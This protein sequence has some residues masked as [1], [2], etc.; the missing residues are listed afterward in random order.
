M[1][2]LI[3]LLCVGLAWAS[4]LSEDLYARL[5]ISRE[6]T[7]REVRVAFKKKAL[8]HHPDKNP[9][10]D[11]AHARMI[12]L[13]QAL[14]I[15]TD[16]DQRAAYDHGGLKAAEAAS[17]SNQGTKY[18]PFSKF[19]DFDAYQ[20]FALYDEDVQV[21]VL[22]YMLWEASHYSTDAWFITFY[23]GEC[24]KCHEIAPE[25]RKVGSALHGPFHVAAVNCDS[26]F[27]VC[28]D[29]GVSALPTTLLFKRGTPRNQ[30]HPEVYDPTRPHTAEQ[31]L[32]F[33]HSH[34]PNIIQPLLPEHF[35][36]PS[37][38]P[39]NG[40]K[41]DLWVVGYC[42]DPLSCESLATQIKLIGM[43][44]GDFVPV[45]MANCEAFNQVC[46]QQRA[47][48]SAPDARAIIVSY[49]HDREIPSPADRDIRDIAYE[50]LRVLKPLETI[51]LQDLEEITANMFLTGARVHK[52]EKNPRELL[53]LFTDKDCDDRTSLGPGTSLCWQ[54]LLSFRQV[55]NALAV[56]WEYGE[57]HPG[58]FHCDEGAQ[59]EARVKTLCDGLGVKAGR[60]ELLILKEGALN[61]NAYHERIDRSEQVLSFVQE[62]FRSTVHEL[63]QDDFNTHVTQEKQTW[64]VDFF[65]PWCHHCRD[66]WPEWNLA[67]K[68]YDLPKDTVVHFGKINCEDHQQ[69]CA[70][71]HIRGYPTF[72][73]FHQGVRHQFDFDHR[74]AEEF[75][76]FIKET[77]EPV[78]YEFTTESYNRILDPFGK[79]VATAEEKEEMLQERW[80]LDFFA[81]WCS[82]CHVMS[83]KFREAADSLR[84]VV[85]F[86]KLNCELDAS[87]CMVLGIQY[88]PTIWRFE[89]GQ[90]RARPTAEYPG[91]PDPKKILDFAMEAVGDD[92][93]SLDASNFQSMVREVGD[94][95]S[96]VV[97]FTSSQ[98]NDCK[99]CER[100]ALKMRALAS[101]YKAKELRQA[102]KVQRMD[103]VAASKVIRL[104]FG[105][106]NCRKSGAE[107]TVCVKQ[108][109]KR[110]PTVMFY[111]GA[112]NEQKVVPLDDTLRAI[113]EIDMH[114][115]S[116]RR[117]IVHPFREKPE[118]TYHDEL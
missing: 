4:L 95:Q 61:P 57:L 79:S 14:V 78:E 107:Y 70:D 87:F 17:K 20:N 5:E 52:V 27:P 67:S 13:N 76:R 9:N 12:E 63:D 36:A 39:F 16:P 96:W 41:G 81:P 88:Y 58:V 35:T 112:N 23:T 80:V 31:F 34:L 3:P 69:Q 10:D 114:L 24:V 98:E 108:R 53:V 105:S 66:V 65:A 60:P 30:Q 22:T 21:Q 92:V 32:D 1:R 71:N 74:T 42:K 64:F 72:L 49:L 104:R 102:D 25:W 19:Q 101:R 86:G 33:A 90:S 94:E 106:I 83:P 29:L 2:V 15:L 118:F 48:A 100:I 6:A 77:L 99:D 68:H 54:T 84:G 37:K 62:T 103:P 26:D 11:H 113:S 59:Q 117:S 89:P 116:D 115:A 51:A 38:I 110:F 40:A 44:L 50:A 85:K 55:L 45:A 109:I 73:L 93:L 56:E 91:L 82:H 7:D 47:F 18:D 43:I 75:V 8:Q 46:E 111:S 97:L 28:K